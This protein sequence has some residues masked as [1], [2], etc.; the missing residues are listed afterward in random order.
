MDELRLVRR[1]DRSLIVATDSGEEFRLVVDDSLL[2]ELRHLSRPPRGSLRINPREVQSLLRSGKTRSEVAA[3]TG[4]E[5]SDIER[6]E[7]PVLAER[8]YILEL[9]QAVPVRTSPG[10]SPEE[11]FGDVI[12]ARLDGL[13]A[14]NV[15]WRSWRD[16]D[17]GWMIGLDFVSRDAAHQ[18]VWSF[19]HRKALLSPVTPH[20]VSLSKQGDLGDQLIPKLRAVDAEDRFDSGAFDPERLTAGI[21]A[22][23]DGDEPE[24]PISSHVAADHPSTGSIPV[25]DAES[26][27]LRRQHIEERA[28]KTPEAEL[29]DLGQTADLL[30]ALRR[31]RGERDVEHTEAV[32]DNEPLPFPGAGQA[33]TGEHLGEPV[34]ADGS[35]EPR[36][37]G[38]EQAPP[39]EPDAAAA[40]S[41]AAEK[42]RKK[43][44][45]AIPSWDDI[46]FGT[47]GDE[48]PS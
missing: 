31:R 36:A 22:Q 12:T 10:E 35:D 11:R 32:R 7:E 38:S 14:E 30:D 4:A 8:R 45:T 9:A 5:E 42:N 28:I 39:A 21:D 34:G 20:A 40:E 33:A 1:E 15:V 46:L 24:R 48:D 19:E 16:E 2:A 44:R 18:A 47:R 26:E 43:G 29:P 6:Y 3:A 27:Y 17:S 23:A 25:I 41:S 13:A 37:D